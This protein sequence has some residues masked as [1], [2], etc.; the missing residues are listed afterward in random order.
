ML[1]WISMRSR[2]NRKN[3]N[4]FG[5]SFMEI[6]IAVFIAGVIATPI[7][8]LFSTSRK[9]GATAKNLME[10]MGSAGSYISA[11]KEVPSDTINE[12]SLTSDSALSGNLS[13]ENLGI[14]AC[15]EG[16]ERKIMVEKLV[17]ELGDTY[18]RVVVEISWKH[19]VT[20]EMR[21]FPLS[22]LIRRE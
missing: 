1:R 22:T 12:I 5:M 11:L 14:P 8:V 18:L 15:R 13:L 20:G 16:L 21:E 19:P 6:M 17:S 9:M 4:R 10:A 3:S 2:L 7:Y